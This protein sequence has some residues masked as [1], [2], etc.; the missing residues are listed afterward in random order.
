MVGVGGGINSDHPFCA[1]PGT[2][3]GGA[4]ILR[5]IAASPPSCTKEW[6][7][8]EWSLLEAMGT[9]EALGTGEAQAR[10]GT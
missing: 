1:M 9:G 2:P 8:G 10:G 4:T 3:G 7:G 5:G 6:F